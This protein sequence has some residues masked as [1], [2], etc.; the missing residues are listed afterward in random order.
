MTI[1]CGN[2]GFSVL[3]LDCEH[4]QFVDH[5]PLAL[6]T[7]PSLLTPDNSGGWSVLRAQRNFLAA[8]HLEQLKA[9]ACPFPLNRTLFVDLVREFE[10][11]S[12]TCMKT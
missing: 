2:G 10:E 11:V 5:F 12:L 7:N 6:P 1:V 4:S 9:R 3:A 8:Q